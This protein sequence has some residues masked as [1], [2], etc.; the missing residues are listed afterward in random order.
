MLA[1]GNSSTTYSI[2]L[3][4]PEVLRLHGM[5]SK[6][7]CD[8]LIFKGSV[9][10]TRVYEWRRYVWKLWRD[11]A[12]DILTAF[13]PAEIVLQQTHSP[14]V[15]GYQQTISHLRFSAHME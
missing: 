2:K 10:Y 14:R 6:R 5:H 15:L 9:H 3:P 4:Y 1:L 7:S 13:V 12:N 8:F 11:V